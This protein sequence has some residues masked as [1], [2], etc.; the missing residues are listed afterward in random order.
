MWR[1][2][3]SLAC[4]SGRRF[5]DDAMAPPRRVLIELRPTARLAGLAAPP[6]RAGAAGPDPGALPRLEALRLDRGFGPARLRASGRGGGLR[7]LGTS[8]ADSFLVRGEVDDAAGLAALLRSA[9]SRAEV[10]GVYADPPVQSMPLCGA[11]P[12]VG[13]AALVA[14]RIGVPALARAG[15]DGA[16]VLVAVV[17]SGINRAWLQARGRTAPLD[18]ERSWVP[19]PELVPGQL[20]V[21]HG[22]MVAYDATIAA[23]SCTLLDLALLRST[24]SGGTLMEGVLSDAILAYAHLLEVIDGP[25]RPA[26]TKGLVVNNS[27]GMF[28]PSW[29]FPIGHPGNYAANLAH[30]FNR[31]VQTL[32][33]AGAD[34]LFA[35]GNCGPDCPDGRC[36]GVVEGAIYGANGHPDVLS[37]AGVDVHKRR[38]G[39]S[40]RGPGRLAAAKPDLAGYT[41]FAG[42]GVYAADSGTS[43]ACPVVAGLVAALRGLLPLA[44][45][46]PTTS[47]QYLRSL[48]I[49]TAEHRGAA[50]WNPDYGHGI[51]SGSRLL[52]RL[53]PPRRRAAA[54]P[55]L[56]L[57]SAGLRLA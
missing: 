56:R 37:V 26:G 1:E 38:V 54:R 53:V 42:S 14:R 46:E 15:L 36:Q 18:F 45:D 11:S 23:P 8:A 48:L 30:P 52:R 57:A 6:G 13:D 49:T 31:I 28:H 50:G 39:Y 12:P 19:R 33:G 29:D 51:V 10:L 41:H 43:A 17:D 24:A 47:P 25:L 34:I 55:G 22:T 4:R 44:A 35:A 27:W 7:H 21:N 5:G 2:A 20:Q 9:A 3:A 32:A 16:G 40:S